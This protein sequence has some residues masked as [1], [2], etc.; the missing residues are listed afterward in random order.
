V[1]QAA[2]ELDAMVTLKREELLTADRNVRS[3]EKL[4]EQQQE[5]FLADQ[6]RREQRELDEAAARAPI[7]LREV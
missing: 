6:Q 1:E 4:R 2:S 5:A 3:L 7:S